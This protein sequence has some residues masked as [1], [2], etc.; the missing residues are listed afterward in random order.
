MIS[1]RLGPIKNADRIIVLNS[2]KIIEQRKHDDLLKLNG[3]Y[4][5]M[6]QAQ[7]EWY[8]DDIS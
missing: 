2:G 5:K 1:H 6:Y 8:I 3:T 4:A 7:A